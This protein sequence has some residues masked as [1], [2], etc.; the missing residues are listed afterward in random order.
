MKTKSTRS[1]HLTPIRITL[2]KEMESPQVWQGVEEERDPYTS[3]WCVN[4]AGPGKTQRW[5]VGP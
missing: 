3:G 5:V 2:L 4:D 1:Y